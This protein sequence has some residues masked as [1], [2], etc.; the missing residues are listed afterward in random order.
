MCPRT[1]EM[2]RK[3]SNMEKAVFEKIA[4]QIKPHG[5][6]EF[7]EWLSFVKN[8]L[9]LSPSDV[10]E[11]PFYFFI[12]SLAVT[13]HGF[14]EPLLDPLIVKRVE[15]LSKLGIP[16]YFSCN[17]S[18]AR[19]DKIEKLFKAGLGFIKFSVDSLTL[20]GMKKIRGGHI[21]YS[22]DIKRIMQ[23]LD[24]KKKGG[25]K[26]T[27][28]VCM[29]KISKKQD[30]EAEQFQKLWKGKDVYSYVKSLDNQW[31]FKDEETE[32][33]KSH[34]ENQYCEFPWTSLS[35]M[36]D[37][38]VVPCTQ[39]FN[40]EMPMGNV[41]EQSLKEIWNSEKYEKFRM[42]HITGEFPKNF[43][44]SKRCDLKTVHD[45]LKKDEE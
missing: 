35:V 17:P 25:Y 9:N 41:N 32:K 44:C 5:R 10:G 45:F 19:L 39:D 16:S 18:N 13:M 27:I 3:I 2:T 20:D 34:Y 4:K 22:D 36:A 8:R 42:M 28:V 14:G 26:T 30:E 1:T 6:K 37:G 29:L 24:L 40:C 15:F 11:N 33:A 43:R 23:I 38:T 12:S 21:D 31:Y 7:D